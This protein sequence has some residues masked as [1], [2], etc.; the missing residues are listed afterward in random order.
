MNSITLQ[1]K[2]KI[3]EKEGDVH[4]AAMSVSAVANVAATQHN[5]SAS[6][7]AYAAVTMTRKPIY[8]CSYCNYKDHTKQ[9]FHTYKRSNGIGF[10]HGL[11]DLILL[12]K[13]LWLKWFT[14]KRI[15]LFSP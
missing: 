7:L 9:V 1:L 8:I 15:M 10:I 3:E 12:P 5:E 2:I 14:L 6:D 13:N 11:G 4:I